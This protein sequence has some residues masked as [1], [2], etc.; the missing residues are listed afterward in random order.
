MDITEVRRSELYNTLSWMGLFSTEEYRIREVRNSPS[1]YYVDLD[2]ENTDI[3]R[4]G[5]L[6]PHVKLKSEYK[7]VCELWYGDKYINPK[8]CTW[9]DTN[10]G[11]YCITDK[12]YDDQKPVTCFINPSI[13]T[14]YTNISDNPEQDLE[15][16]VDIDT[17]D[18]IYSNIINIEH[19]AYYISQNKVRVPTIEWLDAK[20]L[21][22]HAP[23]KED[24]DFFMKKITTFISYRYPSVELLI[25]NK[26]HL[27]LPLS[28]VAIVSKVGELFDLLVNEGVPVDG[29]N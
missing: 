17:S 6:Y 7:D 13:I 15:H 4:V 19:C 20:I 29:K 27:E 9:I 2:L 3:E 26:Y 8:R 18:L 28:S 12:A 5:Y 11:T 25:G 23:Y 22:F 16:V 21:R 14:R 1:K 24:I 10:N